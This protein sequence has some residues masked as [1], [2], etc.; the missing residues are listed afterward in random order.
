LLG[1]LS[2]AAEAQCPG[3]CDGNGQAA[4]NELIGGVNIALDRASVG[5]CPV[6]D[7]DGNNMVAVN[8]LVRGVNSALHGCPALSCTAPEGGRCVE[9]VPGATAQ[10]DLVGALLEAQAHDVVYIKAGRYELSSQLSLTVD[11][12]TIRG[13][14]MGRTILSFANL[15]S[16]GEGILVRANNF[17]IEDVGLEDSPGDLL[18]IEGSNGVTMRRVRAEWTNGSDEDNGSYGLYPVQCTDVL[19][20]D[21]VVKAAS[22]AGVYVGQSRNIIVRRNM[23]QFNV[24]GIEIENSSD[25]DV[26]HNFAT[27][28]TGGILIFNLPGL[29][30]RDGH[31]TRIYNNHVIANNT[32]NFAPA[33]N[34]VAGVPDGTGSFI[35]ANDQVEVFNNVFRDNN[36]SHVSVISYNTAVVLGIPAPNDPLFDPFS[37]TILITGN[38]YQGGGNMPDPDLETL[39][40]LIGGLPIPNIVIDGDVDAD[41][42]VDGQLPDDLRT[43][44]REG[45]AVT[46]VDLDFANGFQ[47][48]NRDPAR[49]ACDHE[50]LPPIVI[51]SHRQVS[52]AAG[53]NAQDALLTALIEAQPGD[54]ITLGAGR[55]DLTS[56]LS[57]R[58]DG[59]TLRGAGID[60]T[61]L[62]FSGLVAAAEGLLVQA[63]HFTLEDLAIENCPG[64]QFKILGANGVTIRRVR[65]E[66]TGGPDPDNGSYGLYPVQCEDVLI[67]DSVVKGASD[68]GVYVGQS[69]NII[70]RRNHVEGNVAGIEIENSTGAD[71]YENM[72]TGNT[73]GILVFNLPGLPVQD[74]K[75]TRVYR[76]EITENNTDNF[77]PGGTVQAVPTG[78]GMMIL[79]NDQVEVF[80]NTFSNNHSSHAFVISYNTAVLFGVPAPNDPDYDPFSES[81]LFTGNTYEGG[82]DMPDPDLDLLVTI[83]NG[84]LPIP[85]LV[86]DGDKDTDKYVDGAL[87]GPLRTCVQEDSV[88]LVDLDATGPDDISH[89]PARLDCTLARLPA[90]AIPG[91]R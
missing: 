41:K 43:C 85:N 68:A 22:D 52:V 48:P 53:P 81:I 47:N 19:I 34:T 79:A 35:L 74:G 36:T 63:N 65:T 37:E 12:V 28:N 24:A 61:V 62:N 5:S 2:P 70:V 51:N 54:I 26:H 11:D 33:G 71:V 78:T 90:I 72:A 89:D 29:P 83:L 13:E 60:D 8:E 56:Q 6:F 4:V 58:V 84:V 49:F 10:D 82:G 69:K 45:T 55:Y 91:V 64:D 27:E 7:G 46:L 87:P 17:T 20:E 21:C 44:I 31:G 30:V 32:H 23:V 77:A 16:G 86:I 14:G 42:K 18:K 50:R 40:T 38:T 25:A 3:D 66:W 9:I 1:A 80:D 39:V 15:A 73:G 88:T 76:N 67:E 57:L 75:R 59:V